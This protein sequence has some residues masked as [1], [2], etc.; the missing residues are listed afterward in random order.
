VSVR[1]KVESH[2]S[3]MIQQGDLILWGSPNVDE[4]KSRPL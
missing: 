3:V 4:R 2:E 1:R